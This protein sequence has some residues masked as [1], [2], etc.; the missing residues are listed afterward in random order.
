M[1][2]INEKILQELLIWAEE[3]ED[4]RVF[5]AISDE[6]KSYFTDRDSEETYIMEY[7]FR[8][9]AEL[10]H[11]L[12]KYSNLLEDPELLKKM[13]IEI[14]QDRFKRELRM[15]EFSGKT[16][17]DDRKEEKEKTLPEYVYAF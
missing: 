8:T 5:Y 2:L 4:K 17:I 9:L 12:E 7:S 10:K 1:S 11:N 13:T 14:C 15:H 3:N 16:N 6:E